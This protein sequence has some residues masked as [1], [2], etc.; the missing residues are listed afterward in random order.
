[1]IYNCINTQTNICVDNI[2]WDGQSEY[3][4]GDNLILQLSDNT[5]NIGDTV[6]LVSGVYKTTVVPPVIPTPTPSDLFNVDQFKSDLL[7]AFSGDSNIFQYYAVFIDLSSFK[8]FSTMKNMIAELLAATK[9]TQDE[10]NIFNGVLM[11]QNID[12]STF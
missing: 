6:A 2:V 4:P 12:L 7:T 3:N 10:V 5:I 11:N 9:I 8:N 1:M